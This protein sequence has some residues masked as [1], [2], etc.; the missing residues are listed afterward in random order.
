MRYY[1]F[2]LILAVATAIVSGCT[3]TEESRCR[4]AAAAQLVGQYKANETD[5]LN[6]FNQQRQQTE[7][8]L[9]NQLTLLGT[10]QFNQQLALGARQLSEKLVSD[11]SQGAIL[12]GAFSDS[13]YNTLLSNYAA[14]DSVVTNLNSI[15]STYSSS[16]SAIKADLSKLDTVK[17]TL[18]SLAMTPSD[19]QKLSDLVS[20]ISKAISDAQQQ[21]KNVTTGQK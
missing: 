2:P 6:K 21:K 10:E 16:K 13:C 19:K 12:P 15:R 7:A 3:T 1:T 14:L 8:A 18:Q 11:S 17:A 9:L 5:R 4:D 20:I